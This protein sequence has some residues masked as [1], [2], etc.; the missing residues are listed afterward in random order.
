MCA[1]IFILVTCADTAQA[2]GIADKLVNERLAAC[3]HIMPPHKSVYHWQGQVTR[4]A[5]VNILIK[6]QSTLFDA[7]KAAVLAVHSYDVPCIV[8]WR[9]EDGH[10]PFMDWVTAQTG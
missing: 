8:S 6:T 10:Q 7:V 1:V 9:A 2:E 5:E 3:V 4:A